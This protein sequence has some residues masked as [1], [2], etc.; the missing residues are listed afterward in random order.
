MAFV[1]FETFLISTKEIIPPFIFTIY[2]TTRKCG[3]FNFKN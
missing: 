2:F 1:K 3:I